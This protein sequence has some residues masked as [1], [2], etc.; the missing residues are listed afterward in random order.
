[1]IRIQH[2]LLF[3]FHSSTYPPIICSFLFVSVENVFFEITLLAV[4]NLV[5]TDFSHCTNSILKVQ[6]ISIESR[7]ETIEKV[8]LLFKRSVQ[9]V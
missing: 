6:Y 2:L 8:I 4:S 7:H 1:M 9:V 3:F 5:S